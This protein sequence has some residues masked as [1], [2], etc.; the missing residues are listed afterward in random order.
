MRLVALVSL[1]VE[2]IEE[3]VVSIRRQVVVHPARQVV[4][5]RADPDVF[6]QLAAALLLRYSTRK[7]RLAKQE[8]P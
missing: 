5:E 3:E 6:G 8:I 2:A 4:E 7:T 1:G